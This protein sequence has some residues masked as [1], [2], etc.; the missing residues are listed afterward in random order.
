MR[1]TST[2]ISVSACSTASSSASVWS[3][4]GANGLRRRHSYH[5]SHHHSLSSFANASTTIS[6]CMALSPPLL[7][8]KQTNHTMSHNSGINP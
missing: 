4:N 3:A 7:R 2:L 6:C 8:S 5:A 1:P